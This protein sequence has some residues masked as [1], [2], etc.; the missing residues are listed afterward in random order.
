MFQEPKEKLTSTDSDESDR[1]WGQRLNALATAQQD[2]FFVEIGAMDGVSFDPLYAVVMKY[3]WRGLL[4]EP[5]PDLFARL[6]ENYK[7][8][9]GVLFENAAIAEERGEKVMYRVAPQAVQQGLVPPWAGGIS[10]FFLDKNA[11]GGKG[12]TDEAFKKILPHVITERVA[13]D[14]LRAILDRNHI[15]KID[16]LQIDTEGYDFQV[17]RQFDFSIFKPVL[18]RMEECNLSDAEK[19]AAIKLFASHGY[20]SAS[21]KMDRIAWRNMDKKS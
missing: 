16:V 2:I 6:K 18:I 15:K 21:T 7:D 8:A 14:T 10:S 4:V 19:T 20:Q 9:T 11:L 1:L 12:V 13:T 3:R 5:L 17:L